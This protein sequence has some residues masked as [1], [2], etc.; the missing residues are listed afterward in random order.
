MA[1]RTYTI[2][3]PLAETTSEWMKAMI[4]VTS[5]ALMGHPDTTV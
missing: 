2:A 5:V 3:K 1:R 4:A